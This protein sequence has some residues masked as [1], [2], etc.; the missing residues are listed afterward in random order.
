MRKKPDR[1]TLL[2]GEAAP[3][4]PEDDL[5]RARRIL[6]ETLVEFP[7]A[8][9]LSDPPARPD[10]PR[11]LEWLERGDHGRMEWMRRRPERRRSLGEGYPGYRS[12]V[13]ALLPVAGKGDP[14]HVFGTSVRIARYAEGPDYHQVFLERFRR[15]IERI[16]PL[17]DS[18]DRP[19]V[20]PDHGALLE[21]SL[22]MEAGLGV[23]G[24]NTL[25]INPLLGSHFTIGSLLLKTPLAS[26]TGPF[27]EFSPCGNC[28]RCLEA[29]PT[30]AFRGPYSLDARRCLSYLTIEAPEDDEREVRRTDGEDWLFGCDVCQ[31]TC[32]HNSS[33][34]RREMPGRETSFSEKRVVNH[35]ED[36]IEWV[37]TNPS[38]DR[39]SLDTL[40][41]RVQEITSVKSG[42]ISGLPKRSD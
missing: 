26:I 17:L 12:I 42:R 30:N 14:V 8:A 23:L 25:L 21:K 10:F 18:G 19:L 37:R 7:C 27:S 29:C 6:G 11:L 31:D 5:S 9:V 13:I 28:T 35:P 40:R 32:P 20:K 1:E 16:R 3:D 38:M 22:A 2:P 41:E 36:L 4:K 34:S 15:I 33:R 24:K 39:V